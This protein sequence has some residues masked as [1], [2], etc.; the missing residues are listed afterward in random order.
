MLFLR[1]KDEELLVVLELESD[2][3]YPFEKIQMESVFYL[4]L[5]Y[6]LLEQ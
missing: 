3:C 4:K 6:N 5:R 2:F 1:S